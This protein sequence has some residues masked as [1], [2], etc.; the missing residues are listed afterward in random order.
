MDDE[1]VSYTANWLRDVGG[2]FLKERWR[3]FSVLKG[4]NAVLILN[5]PTLSDARAAALH[6]EEIKRIV[7]EDARFAPIEAGPAS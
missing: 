1:D 5:Y 2:A 3:D 7:R 4:G 6:I